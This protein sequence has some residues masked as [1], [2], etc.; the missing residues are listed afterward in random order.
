MHQR[1]APAAAPS[2]TAGSGKAAHRHEGA[3][4]H[5]K[6]ERITEEREAKPLKGCTLPIVNK[7][8]GSGGPLRGAVSS[9]SY[10]MGSLK[11]PHSASL[12]AELT[13]PRGAQK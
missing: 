10:Q 8:A 12:R 11:P 1:G 13:S 2:D 5:L 9:P 4:P 3:A 7:V 6:S